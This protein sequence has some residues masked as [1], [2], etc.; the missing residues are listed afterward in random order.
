MT[1]K[2][3]NLI[4]IQLDDK[5]RFVQRADGSTAFYRYHELTDRTPDNAHLV[6]AQE[7]EDL[8]GKLKALTDATG[9]TDK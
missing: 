4:D 3:A 7:I 8:R 5:W 9:A 2:P 1:D 6:M